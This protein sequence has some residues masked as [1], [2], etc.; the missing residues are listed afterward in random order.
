MRA[1]R[2]FASQKIQ[3][4][5]IKVSSPF[6]PASALSGGTQQKV[7]IGK[8]MARQPS[9]L[10]FVDPTRGIDVQTKFNF[11]QMIRD[12]ARNGAACVV[13]SSDT[14]ELVGLCDRVAVF[15]DGVPVGILEGE[16]VTQDAVVAASF[17]VA[18]EGTR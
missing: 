11:Y 18:R 1:E 3:E 8:F 15:H 10:L 16:E 4:L 12:L 7:V 6:Q 5:M 14:E 13:Y 17:A 9:V 2:A